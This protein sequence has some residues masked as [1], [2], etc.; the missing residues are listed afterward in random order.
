MPNFPI[1]PLSTLLFGILTI[2]G[3]AIGFKQAGSQV[4]LMSGFIS[5][6]LLL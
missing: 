2:L 3:G 5:G 4:S 1:A 6:L